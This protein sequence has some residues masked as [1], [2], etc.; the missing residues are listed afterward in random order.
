MLDGDNGGDGADSDDRGDGDD[1]DD[2]E[3][4]ESDNEEQEVNARIERKKN[5]KVFGP[6]LRSKGFIWIASSAMQYAE[7]SQAGCIL[8]LSPGSEWFCEVPTEEWPS[9]PEV[10]ASIKRD[11]GNDPSWKWGD[12]RQELV[13]IGAHLNHNLLREKLDSCLLADREWEKWQKIMSKKM[14]MD[15]KCEQLFNEFG[16]D[17][18][19]CDIVQ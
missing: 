3:D 5:C 10:I 7:W 15:K 1:G 19:L 17:Y 12:R 13:L 16:D 14:S 9:D 4:S 18:G 11:F 8:T 6:L 2:G